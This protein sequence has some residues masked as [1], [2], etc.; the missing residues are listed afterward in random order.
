MNQREIAE[1]REHVVTILSQLDFRDPIFAEA[2]CWQEERTFNPASIRFE[3]G[4]LEKYMKPMSLQDLAARNPHC[5][6]GLCSYETERVLEACSFGPMHLLGATARECGFQ[7]PFLTQLVR[8]THDGLFWS[9]RYLERL[10][11]SAGAKGYRGRALYERLALAWNCGPVSLSW[12]QIPED[13]MTG[14][15]VPILREYE[16]IGGNFEPLNKAATI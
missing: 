11:K 15:V 4:F 6:S 13:R 2:I 14:Y 3:P 10:I 9:Q 5:V 12:G 16:R 7:E 8:S 1:N